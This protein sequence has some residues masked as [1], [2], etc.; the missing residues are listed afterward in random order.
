MKVLVKIKSNGPPPR[1][2]DGDIISIVNDDHVFTETEKH[3]FLV[4]TCEETEFEN[5]THAAR[6]ED[7]RILTR[8]RWFVP[9]WELFPDNLVEIRTPS[10][11][12]DASDTTHSLRE[13]AVDKKAVGLLEALER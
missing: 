6:G 12:F 2:Q 13:I 11:V 10:I 8:R 5:Y 4:I 9:Y 1:Y 3:M 7:N